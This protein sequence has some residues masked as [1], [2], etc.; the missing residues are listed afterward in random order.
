[1]VSLVLEVGQVTETVE[2]QAD[3]T[4]VEARATGIGTTITNTQILQLPLVGRQA[5]DLISLIGGN[6]R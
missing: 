5:Q 1:V 6:V 4:M 3:A 2:V